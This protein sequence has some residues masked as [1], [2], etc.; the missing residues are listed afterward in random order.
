MSDVAAVPHFDRTAILKLPPRKVADAMATAFRLVTEGKAVNPAR[1]DIDLGD[2]AATHL[3]SGGFSSLDVL[4]VK[5]IHVRPQ[6]PAEGL[7]RLQGGLLAFSYRTGELLATI[8]A[9]TA[10]EVRTAACSALSVRLL[11]PAECRVMTVFGTAAQARGNVRAI[12]AERE[13]EE[14][15]VVGRSP[16]HAKAFAAEND[17]SVAGSAE[18]ALD[19]AA[20][21][22]AATNSREPIFEAAEVDRG[23]HICAVGNGAHD[24]QELDPR[25]FGRCDGIYVDHMASCLREAGESIAALDA[26]IVRR[27]QVHELGE[28]LT[29]HVSRRPSD[30]SITCFKSVGHGTQDA[31]FAALLL[32]RI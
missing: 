31:A 20:I 12:R 22:V 7:A 18:E 4:T 14:V 23:T 2:L 15:R 26:R 6:N 3:I 19:G 24:A 17:A 16:E 30:E 1:G 9:T 11:A 29:G 28:L 21:V 32:G 10:T 27:E 25:L 13:I 5:V 8:D